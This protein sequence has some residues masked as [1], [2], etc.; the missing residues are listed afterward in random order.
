M[1]ALSEGKINYIVECNPLLGPDLAK[2]IKTLHDGGTVEHSHRDRG[3]R[4]RKP[5][6]V[7]GEQGPR[8]CGSG[9]RWRE[10]SG[11]GRCGRR[12]TCQTAGTF[13]TPS[14]RSRRPRTRSV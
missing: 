1:T 3:R 7:L 13:A 11:G 9:S 4:C 6:L 8:R 12:P 5:W 14:G 10:E 2:I